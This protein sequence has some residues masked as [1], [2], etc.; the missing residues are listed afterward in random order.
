MIATRQCTY[1]LTSHA[2]FAVLRAKL[3]KVSKVNE[4][5]PSTIAP[6]QAPTIAIPGKREQG[7]L[8]P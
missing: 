6:K 8:A 4:D 7:L 2:K 1:S 5:L 3:S